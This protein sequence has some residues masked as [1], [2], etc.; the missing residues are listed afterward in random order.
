MEKETGV[1]EVAVRR[2]GEAERRSS[3][4]A[5]G[6]LMRPVLMNLAWSWVVKCGMVL[7]ALSSGNNAVGCGEVT[8]AAG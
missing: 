1:G 6:S 2:V 4:D 8:V 7:H 3:A 5:R